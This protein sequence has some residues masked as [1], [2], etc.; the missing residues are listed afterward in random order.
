MYLTLFSKVGGNVSLL[1]A[2]GGCATALKGNQRRHNYDM[3]F[4]FYIIYPAFNIEGLLN[5]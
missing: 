1:G 5:F 2:C 4:E 3:Y